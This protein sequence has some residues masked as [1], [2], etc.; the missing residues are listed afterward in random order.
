MDFCNLKINRIIIHEIFKRN[1]EGEIV[2]PRYSEALSILDDAGI[3]VLSDRIINSVG[4]NA[5]SME[6]EISNYQINSCVEISNRLI[7]CIKDNDFINISKSIAYK[8]AEAQTTR[9]MPG[10]IVLI[11]DATIGLSNKPTIGIIK[12]EIHSGF[13][14]NANL[15]DMVLQ[16]IS[17]LLLTPQQKLY[18]VVLFIEDNNDSSLELNQRYC[19]YIYDHNMKRAETKDAATYF[20]ST[21]LGCNF[22]K[23]SKI[24]TRNFYEGSREF[25][26]SLDITDEEKFDINMQLYSYMKS[27]IT[28]TL[29]I[30]DFAENNFPIEIRDNYARHMKNKEIPNTLIQKDTTFIEN[31]LKQRKIKFSND[32]SI[33]G[34][35]E[36]FKELI[37]VISSDDESTTL[38]INGTIK[39]QQ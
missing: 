22:K 29:S 38:K 31:R 4:G 39:D 17:E 11:F 13:T 25:I 36:K 24:I 15:H 33:M 9:R 14:R 16:Y 5:Y 3:E 20:Y 1:S 10:G 30:D 2:E 18:K 8:L 28:T 19:S 37:N 35:S 32:I 23:N 26:N 27:P 34:P 6:M 12:A 21:F 7:N